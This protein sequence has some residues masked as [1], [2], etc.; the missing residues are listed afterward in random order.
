MNSFRLR[1][2]QQDWVSKTVADRAAGIHRLLLDAVGGS[3]KT[4]YAGALAKNEWAAC[5]GRTLILENRKQL[6]EQTAKRFADETGLEVDVEMADRKAS[7]YAQVVVASV[8]SL[9][10]VGRLTGFADFHFNLV[11]ADEAHNSTANLFMRIMRYFHYGA[12]SLQD[13]WEA[14]KDGTYTPKATIIGITATPDN[15]G[16]RNLG[17]FYQKFVARYSYL[18]AIEDGW[19]VGIKEENIPV[20]IDCRSFRKKASDFGTDFSAEDEAAVIIP[21]IDS[22]ANQIVKL[23]MG[24]KTMCYLPTKECVVQMSSALNRKG[25]KSLYVIGDCLDRDE[26]TEEFQNHGRGICL[27][28]CAMYVEGTDFPTVSSV[29]WM[30]PTL[31]PSFYKQGV[32]RM[33]RALPGLVNDD[34]TAEERRA[35]IANSEKPFGLLIS[36]FYVSDKVDIMSSIDLFVDQ[37]IKAAKGAPKDLT[38]PVKIRDYIKQLERAADKHAHKQAR[39]INPVAFSLSVGDKKLAA[40]QPQC[41]ADA[42]PASQAEKDLLLSHSIDTTQI[43]SSG[44]AQQLI[45]T[46]IERDRLGLAT[47]KQ[48]Q[49]LMLRFHWPEE[50]ATLVKKNHAGVIIWKGIHYKAPKEEVAVQDF[51]DPFE[52]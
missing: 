33:S 27:C 1:G 47:P 14:P 16:K 50:K 5:K 21:I 45:K 2:Y 12:Q 42:A 31:S 48:L 13:G 11:F 40:Y 15:Y 38:D 19:L 7:P 20:K 32:Y 23:A 22:L 30:R 49:Q 8:A 6:V 29:A 41:D 37:S 18:E 46:L 52:L 28:L 9:G 51:G 44:Q 35:A 36:P 24:E 39:T 26:K 43:K 25:L 4:S 3:G 34:M 10:L 17:N